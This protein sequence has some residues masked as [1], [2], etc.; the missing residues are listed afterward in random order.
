M[1]QEE[2]RWYDEKDPCKRS[3]FELLF[4]NLLAAPIIRRKYCRLERNGRILI[5]GFGHLIQALERAEAFD[6]AVVLVSNH[7][8]ETDTT[9][10]PYIVDKAGA[11]CYKI[12]KTE[13]FERLLERLKMYWVGVRPID[14]DAGI[15]DLWIVE[16]LIEARKV[17]LFFPTG[18]RDP[19]NQTPI[20][21]GISV[22]AK[23]YKDAC[24]IVPAELIGTDKL[25]E[26]GYAKVIFKPFLRPADYS[27]SMKGTWQLT[28]EIANAINVPMPERKSRNRTESKQTPG[29]SD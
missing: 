10:L 6:R 26:G 14:R 23:K 29:R 9:L 19:N 18:H 4:Y 24:I 17:V 16:K 11:F 3:V 1:S 27:D 8:D 2:V 25:K 15:R 22:I 21:V 13:L 28:Q 20:E 12:G 5:K 7:L